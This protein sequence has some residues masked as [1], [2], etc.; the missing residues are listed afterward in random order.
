M[1]EYLRRRLIST[2]DDAVAGFKG[3]R[4]TLNGPILEV[5]VEI[6]L[7]TT[8]FFIPLNIEVSQITQSAE[9]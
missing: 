2:S 7:S 6:K 1:N 8:I 4:V 5:S 3:L 9:G